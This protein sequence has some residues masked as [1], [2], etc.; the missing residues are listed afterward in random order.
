[1]DYSAAIRWSGNMLTEP[2]PSNGHIPQNILGDVHAES[3]TIL[4]VLFHSPI[5]NGCVEHFH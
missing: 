3:D 5:E 2:L 1:M 4:P